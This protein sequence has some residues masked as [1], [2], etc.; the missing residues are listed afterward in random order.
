MPF[1][2]IETIHTTSLGKRPVRL[3]ISEKEA[4][5]TANRLLTNNSLSTHANQTLSVLTTAGVLTTT[6]LR[7]LVRISHRSLN[8]Y[9]QQHLINTLIAPDSLQNF[10]LPFGKTIR[11]QLHTL[12]AVGLAVAELRE[13]LGSAYAG[14]GA[15]QLIHDVLCN[16]VALN[17]I[18]HGKQLGYTPTWYG[19]YE[20]RVY[21][22]E[23]GKTKCVLEPDT[24]LIFSQLNKPKRTFI[25]EYHNEDHRNRTTDKVERYEREA[26]NQYWRDTWPLDD[27]PVVLAAFTHKAVAAGYTEAVANVRGRGLRCQFLGK[28]F[29]VDNPDPGQWWDFDKKKSV[30]IF[31]L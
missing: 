2:I 23:S 6:Q 31:S 24:L 27:F 13:Q 7:S 11:L 14:Y 29:A 3:T 9:H 16:Q 21:G 25:I 15:H 4:K 18:Q 22:Q 26:R 30:D 17:L 19:K 1:S 20:A 12:G 5:A 28:Q 8:R 10:R